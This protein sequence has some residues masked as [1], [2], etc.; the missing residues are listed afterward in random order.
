[1]DIKKY[2]QFSKPKHFLKQE[3]VTEKYSQNI[4]KH[5]VTIYGV[6]M[7]NIKKHDF[8]EFIKSEN[9]NTKKFVT[10][11]FLFSCRYLSTFDLLICDDIWCHKLITFDIITDDDVWLNMRQRWSQPCRN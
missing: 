7:K 5:F 6:K 3:F 8:L 9:K 10:I 1:M 11:W 2:V 4:S